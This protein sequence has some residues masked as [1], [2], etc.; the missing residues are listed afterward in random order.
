VLE[1]ITE[2]HARAIQHK[3]HQEIVR[4]WDKSTASLLS[5]LKKIPENEK[6]P[7]LIQIA[8]ITLSNMTADTE[9]EKLLETLLNEQV[10]GPWHNELIT[11]YG[12]LPGN[13]VTR[14]IAKA[15]TWLIRQPRDAGLLHS[16][17]VLCQ[18]QRLWGKAQSYFEAALSIAK[19]PATHLA[20][21]KL[22][23]QLDHPETANTHYR[24]AALLYAKKSNP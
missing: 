12:T 8:A 19:Q 14:R 11:L 6:N 2:P 15:E 3:A 24:E 10:D 21:A 9:A 23:D 18:R 17:G 20:L 7:H 22:L 5:Y 4:L 13:D 1:D 16:L